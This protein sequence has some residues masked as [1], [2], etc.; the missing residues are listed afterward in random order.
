MVSSAENVVNDMAAAYQAAAEQ[1]AKTLREVE[2][3]YV[4]SLNENSLENGV[5]E[6]SDVE[7]PHASDTGEA[8]SD[9]MPP[10]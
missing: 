5:A 4:N 3:T 8:P 6:S 10:G 9:E 1:Y 7:D 2:Q